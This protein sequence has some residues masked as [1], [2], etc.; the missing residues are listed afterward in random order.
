MKKLILFFF[1]SFSLTTLF[2]QYVPGRATSTVELYTKYLKGRDTLT[3]ANVTGIIYTD[4]LIL[5]SGQKLSGIDTPTLQMVLTKD[6]IATKGIFTTGA[7]AIGVNTPE[8][9]A[10]L[11][12]NSVSK[13]VL[14]PRMTTTQREAISNPADG[15][16]VYDTDIHATFIYQYSLWWQQ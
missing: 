7:S 11:T 15:L 9:T 13:G 1:F 5:P 3:P 14:L 4:T 12:I 10:I 6:S 2:S 16:T 8:T